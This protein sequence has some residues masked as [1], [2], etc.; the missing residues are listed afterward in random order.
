M[1]IIW[2]ADKGRD[3]AKLPVQ[4]SGLLAWVL[5]EL[6]R[7]KV[8]L[9]GSSFTKIILETVHG[10][11]PNL[12]TC[13]CTHRYSKVSTAGLTNFIPPVRLVQPL[14]FVRFIAARCCQQHVK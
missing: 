12:S 10:D 1:C 11:A 9:A 5:L 13:G 2:L 6:A 3:D 4:T 14:I 7:G 8:P